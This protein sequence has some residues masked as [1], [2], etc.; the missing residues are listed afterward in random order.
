M[1]G[2]YNKQFVLKCQSLDKQLYEVT[3]KDL[4]TVLMDVNNKEYV[5]FE[6]CSFYIVINDLYYEEFDYY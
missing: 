6:F 5:V 4:L 2:R 1:F 3:A